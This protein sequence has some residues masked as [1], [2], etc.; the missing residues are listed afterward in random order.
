MLCGLGL[1]CPAS[2]SCHPA[3]PSQGIK[4]QQHLE[5]SQNR[6]TKPLG[7][8]EKQGL[9]HAFTPLITVP[10]PHL[11]ESPCSCALIPALWGPITPQSTVV[12]PVTW[13]EVV[14]LSLPDRFCLSPLFLDPIVGKG[15]NLSCAQLGS[16]L[17]PKGR[18][19]SPCPT[20]SAV[21]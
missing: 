3:A 20:A 18:A 21:C 6:A 10:T 13:C 9:L 7:S 8:Q 16:Y 14:P 1:E 2:P 5:Q 17:Q 4:A 15:W 19:S 11:P 12:T